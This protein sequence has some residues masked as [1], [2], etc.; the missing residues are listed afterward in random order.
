MANDKTKATDMTASVAGKSPAEPPVS[1]AAGPR[2]SITG[3]LGGRR[4]AGFA[5]G[6]E[7]VVIDAATLPPEQGE[8]L[9]ADP[10]LSVRPIR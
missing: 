8:A 5:F 9:L 7:P 2:L 4:R 1:E 6:P 10:A 3:P